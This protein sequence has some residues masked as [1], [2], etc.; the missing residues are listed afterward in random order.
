MW[1][2]VLR[3]AQAS[4]GFTLI[5]VLVATLLMLIVTA[6]IFAVYRFQMFALKAQEAQ[7]DAQQAARSMMDLMSREVRLAGYDPTCAKTFNGLADARPQRLQVQLDSNAN[8]AIGAGES[9]IYS[10]DTDLRQISRSAGGAAIPL[11]S[12]LPA[13]ALTFS[14]YDG[15]GVLL[16]PSGNPPALTASQLGAVRR[17]KILLHVQRSSTDPLNSRSVASDLISNVVLR[18][19][20]LNNG[21]ACP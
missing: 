13:N 11:V 7:L 10:Y 18:N 8:G 17:V 4:P 15:S 3:P 16:T 14:Y 21:V 19:R 6:T 1:L 2:T 20:F 12:S 5:E 9:I